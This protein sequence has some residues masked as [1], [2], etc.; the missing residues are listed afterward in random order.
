[1]LPGVGCASRGVLRG[2][3]LHGGC[4]SQHALRQTPP[5]DRMTDACENIT[6]R[7]FVADGNYVHLGVYQHNTL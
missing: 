2:G 5:V 4:A 7:H 6:L 1:M 3:C